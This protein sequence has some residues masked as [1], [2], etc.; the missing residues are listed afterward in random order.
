MPRPR[1]KTSH[2]SHARF[3]GSQAIGRMIGVV[4]VEFSAIPAGDSFGGRDAA[5]GLAGAGKRAN[6]LPMRI[7]EPNGL[8]A[9]LRFPL[10]HGRLV[11]AG[12]G[13]YGLVF[14][15]QSLFTVYAAAGS[16][17]AA[18]AGLVSAMLAFGAFAVAL[19]GWTRAALGLNPP[20]AWLG[21]SLGG[22]ELR[23][24]WV[25]LLVAVLCLTILGTAGFVLLLLLIALTMV[26]AYNAGIEGQPEGFIDTFALFGPG[27]W[28]ATIVGVSLYAVFS[29]WLF[30][31]LSL[32]IPATIDRGRIAILSVW[33]LS[34]GRFVAITTSAALIIV[35][36]LL[37]LAGFNALSDAVSGFNPAAAQS[38]LNANDDVAGPVFG[39]ALLAFV[40]GV[41]KMVL[42]AAPLTGLFAALY[43]K[44]RQEN[45]HRLES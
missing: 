12:A 25:A 28:F 9:A 32:S 6:C 38:I 8:A 23:L 42:L 29:I 11:L 15:V 10:A 22:D 26:G 20:P 21:L 44:Y 39:F 33:P 41:L 30:A 5:P 4:G 16:S 19:A 1:D 35:P 31:R 37:L 24:V 2:D 43:V 34:S 14:T 36:A 3:L 27:E 40:Y 13:L 45:A 17:G 18:L 7:L